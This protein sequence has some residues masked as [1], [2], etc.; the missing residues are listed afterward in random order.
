MVLVN[1]VID[2]PNGYALTRLGGCGRAS[3]KLK[4][5]QC[6]VSVNLIHWPVERF[7]IAK[8]VVTPH[9]FLMGQLEVISQR[10]S[11]CAKFSIG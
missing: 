4:M 3:C 7:G 10:L 11:F 5:G 2:E 6:V 9:G 1:T 8:W